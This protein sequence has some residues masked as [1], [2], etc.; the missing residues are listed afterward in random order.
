MQTDLGIE[1]LLELNG[2][3]IQQEH[4]FWVE[5][6]VWRVAPAGEVPHGIRYA[7]TLHERSGGRVMGYDNAHAVKPSGKYRYA[8]QILQ[9]DHKHSPRRMG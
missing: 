7:L 4:G 6:H 5:V 8:G 3:I 2:S 9:Y 1:T